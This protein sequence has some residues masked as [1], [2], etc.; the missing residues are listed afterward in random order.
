MPILRE[1]LLP[2]CAY[3]GGKRVQA[4]TLRR[5]MMVPQDAPFYD[6]CCGGGAVTLEMVTKGKPPEL[7]TMVDGG[8]WGIFWREIGRG[9]YDLDRLLAHMRRLPEHA[10]HWMPA[11]KEIAKEPCP[12]DEVPYL[13]PIV[14]AAAFGGTPVGWADGYFVG[15]SRM[16]THHVKPHKL[17]TGKLDSL[18]RRRGHIVIP[19]LRNVYERIVRLKRHMAGMTGVHGYVQQVTP[20][21]GS[22]VY[23]DP[24]YEGTAGYND[25]DLDVVAEARRM[26]VPTYVSEARPLTET[27]RRVPSRYRAKVNG[28]ALVSTAEWLSLFG[29]EWPR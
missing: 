25:L 6:L 9:T 21:P 16:A 17:P 18:V 3:M 1:Q 22:V 15:V 14:Q 20:V 26:G 27:A 29:G 4:P 28:K 24:P 13:F 8:P 12:E 7:C 5:M 2:P 11:L 10:E 19:P 23:I